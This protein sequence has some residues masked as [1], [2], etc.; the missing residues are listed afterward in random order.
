[1]H[2]FVLKASCVYV[3]EWEWDWASFLRLPYPWPPKPV[4]LESALKYSKY[5]VSFPVQGKSHFSSFTFLC[6]RHTHTH[7]STHRVC[8]YMCGQ[9]W[10]SWPI[11]ESR[12]G[13]TTDEKPFGSS[14]LSVEGVPQKLMH[15]SNPHCTY[16]KLFTHI[17]REKDLSSAHVYQLLHPQSAEI[18]QGRTVA[19]WIIKAPFVFTLDRLSSPISGGGH[20]M[21]KPIRQ[22]TNSIFVK[23]VPGLF[24]DE[25]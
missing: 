3:R 20:C 9:I 17:L 7:I 21:V 5:T 24:S 16:G 23:T 19:N 1:M 12:R 2:L 22:K 10:P 18:M 6:M 11:P 14:A 25:R 4:S 8:S 13:G 15:I